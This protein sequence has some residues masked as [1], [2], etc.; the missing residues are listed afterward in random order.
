MSTALAAF[1]TTHRVVYG[2]HY[3]TT[4]V[5]TAAE[6]ARATGL[7]RAF[8]GVVGVADTTDGGFAS[9]Q[10]LSCFARGELHHAVLT[11]TG[12]ELCEVT[13]RTNEHCALTGTKLDVVDHGTHGNVLQR[14]GI[15]YFGSGR[16][17]LSFRERGLSYLRYPR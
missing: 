6:P 13:G 10:N 5:R 4:V 16:P 15:T 2:V 7:T 11:F 1:T 8:E 14:K 3:N 17:Y 9:T 12:S